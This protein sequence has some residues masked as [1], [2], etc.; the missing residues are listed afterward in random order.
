ML[1]MPEIGEEKTG[2]K[3]DCPGLSP[4][5]CGKIIDTARSVPI[6]E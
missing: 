2:I 1:L 6:Q 3:G 5:F 4:F